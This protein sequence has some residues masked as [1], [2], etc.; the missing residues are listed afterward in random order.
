[1]LTVPP[2][3][4]LNEYRR[5]LSIDDISLSVDREVLTPIVNYVET[6]KMGARALR[7]VM[8]EILED[9]MFKAPEL[10]GSI[11]R[12]TKRSVQKK[13]KILEQ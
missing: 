9:I 8:E 6:K 12:L 1:M 11:V 4:I 7:T 2:D 10:K 13:L 5:L 3:S